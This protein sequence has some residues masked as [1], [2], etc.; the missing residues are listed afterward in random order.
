MELTPST[1]YWIM[2]ADSIKDGLIGLSLA[3]GIIG[4]FVTIFCFCEE[5]KKW[6]GVVTLA[7]LGTV[8]LGAVFMPNTNTIV[9]M[10]G[11]PASIQAAKGLEL[12]KTAELAVKALNS[13]LDTV[14]PKQD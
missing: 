10:Y 4:G 11:V 8:A 3:V 13:W 2:Q 14:K 7:V 6:P 9:A 1:I 5:D 12:D